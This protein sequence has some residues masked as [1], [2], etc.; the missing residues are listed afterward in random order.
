[1]KLVVVQLTNSGLTSTPN[2]TEFYWLNVAVKVAMKK[3]KNKKEALVAVFVA[4]FFEKKH[5]Q[6]Q[7]QKR[8][9]LTTALFVKPLLLTVL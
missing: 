3:K 1:M 9:K 4:V 7:Q 6:Q 8:K 2:V 5:Q